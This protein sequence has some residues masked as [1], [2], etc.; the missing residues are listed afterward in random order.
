MSM[1]PNDELVDCSGD[2]IQNPDKSD[3][4]DDNE[5]HDDESS[6]WEDCAPSRLRFVFAHGFSLIQRTDCDS[7]FDTT[8][9]VLVGTSKT[10]YVL[11]K[12]LRLLQEVAVGKVDGITHR[13]HRAV[14]RGR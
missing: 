5:S 4:D 14:Q 3:N 9:T 11:H 12:K 10:Q 6:M 2:D 1:I 13:R 8:V 7:G